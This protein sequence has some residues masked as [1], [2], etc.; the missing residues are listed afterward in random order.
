MVRIRYPLKVT[1][2][3]H[4]DNTKCKIS[5]KDSKK[6]AQLKIWVGWW[7][8]TWD[9]WR[10]DYFV[11]LNRTGYFGRMKLLFQKKYMKTWEVNDQFSCLIIWLVG[12]NLLYYLISSL[13]TRNLKAISP[14]KHFILGRGSVSTNC[15]TGLYFLQE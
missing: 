5:S 4:K 13:P 9:Q 12:D 6:S 8:I 15:M 2:K 10:T 1:G 7:R 14:C 3:S 11:R